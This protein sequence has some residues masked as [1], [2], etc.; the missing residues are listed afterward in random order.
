MSHNLAN[1]D[2]SERLDIELQ[3]RARFLIWQLKN[4]KITD[5]EIREQITKEPEATRE[6]LRDLLNEYR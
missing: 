5:L 1:L 2:G 6:R 3:K 4:K